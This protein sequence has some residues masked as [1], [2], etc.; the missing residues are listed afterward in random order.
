ME[1]RQDPRKGIRIVSIQSQDPGNRAFRQRM[2][3]CRKH[4]QESVK[5]RRR[6]QFSDSEELLLRLRTVDIRNR[7]AQLAIALRER[8]ALDRLWLVTDLWRRKPIGRCVELV[9]RELLVTLARRG[10]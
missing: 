5:I 10:D 4:V 7:G 6:C 1:V 9:G 3:D 8:D 2:A